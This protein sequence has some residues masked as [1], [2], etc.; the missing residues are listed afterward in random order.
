MAACEECASEYK[1]ELREKC[2]NYCRL[3][4]LEANLDSNA[5]I[6]SEN[7]ESFAISR[8][9]ATALRKFASSKTLKPVL[10][11]KDYTQSSGSEVPITG[12]DHFD[13]SDLAAI[14]S[15]PEVEVQINGND[16]LDP[17]VNSKIA[18]EHGHCNKICNK[19][20]I[21]F[22]SAK[23]WEDI[24]TIFPSAI[25]IPVTYLDGKPQDCVSCLEENNAIANAYDELCDWASTTSLILSSGQQC[26]SCPGIYRLVHAKDFTAL[27]KAL[28]LVKNYRKRG[29]SS[30]TK[31]KD[32]IKNVLYSDP[33]FIMVQGVK[34]HRL[35]CTKHMKPLLSIKAIQ[36]I[37]FQSANP[38]PNVKAEYTEEVPINIMHEENY[39]SYLKSLLGI[40][41]ILN[42]TTTSTCTFFDFL[43][44][45]E[46]YHPELKVRKLQIPHA[47]DA[48]QIKNLIAALIVKSDH[49][50]SLNKQP[51]NDCNCINIYHR[52]LEQVKQNTSKPSAEIK[53]EDVSE[54]KGDVCT[55]DK[56]CYEI[57]EYDG[58]M[59]IEEIQNTME[60]EWSDKMDAIGDIQPA[61]RRSSRKKKSASNNTFKLQ[62]KKKDIFAQ[63]R[64]L[65][66]EKSENK[67]LS[68]H[69]LSIFSFDKSSRQGFLIDL[70]GERNDH[71]MH[72]VLSELPV[73]VPDE[74]AVI[75]VVLSS[76]KINPTQAKRGFASDGD[77]DESLF[78]MLLQMATDGQPSA[79]KLKAPRNG[80][81]EERGFAGTFLQSSLNVHPTTI[82]RKKHYTD[83]SNLEAE[84]PVERTIKDDSS[85]V[86][87]IE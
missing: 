43:S 10:A 8:S 63:F 17:L 82:A 57:H 75:H 37:H 54:T 31:L 59:E 20:T 41:N 48:I 71:P 18:C 13:E 42:D 81:R 65:V 3:V 9:F 35:T 50:F 64:L 83:E 7:E 16:E 78:D 25:S 55:S 40:Q 69:R 36:E 68:S 85:V 1:E 86:H 46:R 15:D 51:C 23:T 5:L 72:K 66:Y 27:N 33:S 29:P 21:R 61:V 70:L 77:N 60:K 53:N 2:M 22:L 76:Q 11:T 26:E 87:L 6:P 38:M 28:A 73:T 84:I 4:R 45:V 74:T 56:F 32:D 14:I 24:N 49:K 79:H 58:S 47:N 12:I 39:A 30:L 44:H 52:N 67:K 19:K 80:R 62:A 34:I